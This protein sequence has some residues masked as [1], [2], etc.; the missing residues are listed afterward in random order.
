[1]AAPAAEAAEGV[2]SATSGLT[3]GQQSFCDSLVRIGQQAARTQHR[4][5]R[6]EYAVQAG[7][8]LQ[9]SSS[10][11]LSSSQDSQDSAFGGSAVD[12]AAP[13]EPTGRGHPLACWVGH[14]DDCEL[15]RE[16]WATLRAEACAPCQAAR[17]P[18]T[19]PAPSPTP[20]DLPRP[21]PTT[22]RRPR[23][24]R[25]PHDAGAPRCAARAVPLRQLG[26]RARQRAA[27]PARLRRERHP[28]RVPRPAGVVRRVQA[29]AAA[30]RRDAARRKGAAARPSGVAC[31]HRGSGER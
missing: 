6:K 26:A 28:P 19:P 20:P 9:G 22:G 13:R 27:A 23:G 30:V 1:M 14:G 8:R 2:L 21:A 16:G 18:P 29:A 17:E 15:S 25:P 12:A 5:Y 24:L 7:R 11:E 3:A 31:A 4:D 10:G